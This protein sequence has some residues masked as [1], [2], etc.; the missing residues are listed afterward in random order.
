MTLAPGTRL[1]PYE[2]LAPLGAGGMGEVYRARDPKLANREVAVK[3]L[4]GDFLEGEERRARFERE[5]QPAREPEPSRRSPPSTHS[6]KSG[7]SLPL[8]PLFIPSSSWSCSRARRCARASPAARCPCGR[9]WSSARRSPAASRPRTRRASSTATSSPRTSSSRRTAGSRSSTSASRSSSSRS[10]APAR[11]TS[12]RSRRGRSRAPSSGRWATCRPSSCAACPPTTARTSSASARSSTRCSPGSKCVPRRHGG[13]HRV[14][15][16]ARGAARPLRD[17]PDD[18]ARARA[19]RSPL[20][21]EEPG[22]ARAFRARPRVRP[23][24]LLDG[25]LG[26]RGG[27]GSAGRDPAPVVR[28]PPRGRRVPRSRRPRRARLLWKTAAAG[29]ADVPPPHVPARKRPRGRASR[30][31]AGRS[32]T[33]RRGAGRRRRSSRCGPRA[34]SPGLSASRT[35]RSR[36]SRPRG[37]LAILSHEG[38]KDTGSVGHALAG[39]ALRRAPR[40]L[41]EE[42][43]DADWTPDGKDLAV[44]RN[45]DTGGRRIELPAGKVLY[46]TPSRISALRVSPDGVERRLRRGR[47]EGSRPEGRR[48]GRAGPGRSPGRWRSFSGR[49]AWSASG[50]EVLYFGGRDRQDAALRAVDL[51]GR[52]RTLYRSTGFLFVHDVFPDGRMLIEHAAS[53][54]RSHVRA[55]RRSGPETRALDGSTPREVARGRRRG[56]A[57]SSSTRAARR[58]E[59]G[60]RRSSG[61]RTARPPCGSRTAKAIA[62]SPGRDSR[63]LLRSGNESDDRA[64]RRRH[65][66]AGRARDHR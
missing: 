36:R 9:P 4:P 56:T 14:G 66:G 59:A 34:P 43:A 52:V 1:G 60:R 53:L 6:K 16:P 31:T 42:I 40:P 54:Q 62:L 39:P 22:R 5:A 33:A 17:E 24:V 45:Q 44:I 61:R 21:R 35:R 32:S 18:P 46:Q 58:S 37:E 48:P 20:P 41:L 49:F 27:V 8:R 47:R 2:I 7:V 28:R 64:G 10:A 11:R 23:R 13:R 65:S 15:D 57:P 26:H 51:S 29:A 19:H 50:R 3:V 12:R 30:P 25:F 55:R 63:V 38:M